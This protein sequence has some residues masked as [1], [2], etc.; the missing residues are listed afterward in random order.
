MTTREREQALGQLRGPLGAHKRVVEGTLRARLDHTA[1]RNAEIADDDGQKV[2]E[3]VR[4]AAG[5][6]ADGFHFLRL[7]QGVLG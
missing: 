4:Y 7:P 1:P 3:V 6:L 2:V 5:Q